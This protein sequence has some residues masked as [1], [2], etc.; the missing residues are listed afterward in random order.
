MS[1]SMNP[2]AKTY[3]D[4]LSNYDVGGAGPGFKFGKKLAKSGWQ[5]LNQ[6]RS[7]A[8]VSS[9]PI[10]QSMQQQEARQLAETD[11]DYMTGGNALLT[12]GGGNEGTWLNAMRDRA[13]QRVKES[14]GENLAK[15][16]PAYQQ[17][18]VG[19]ITAG[20]NMATDAKNAQRNAELSKYGTLIGGAE[21]GAVQKPSMWGQILSGALGASSGLITKI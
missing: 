15:A 12:Q 19:Q 7:G 10:F 5:D 14:S 2:F 6:L 16:L 21:K 13:K 1:W 18:L 11:S 3:M 17:G 8:D 4:Q 9:M 20:G